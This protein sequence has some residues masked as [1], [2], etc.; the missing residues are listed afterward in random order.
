M[1]KKKK[2]AFNEE[3][4]KMNEVVKEQPVQIKRPD[5]AQPYPYLGSIPI[6]GFDIHRRK[7]R[8][9]LPVLVKSTTGDILGVVVIGHPGM[10]ELTAPAMLEK[11]GYKKPF[12][13]LYAD[14]LTAQEKSLMAL[15]L[16]SSKDKDLDVVSALAP[17]GRGSVGSI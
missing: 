7:Y 16:T 3:K 14:S 6:P 2:N 9:T 10:L 12:K 17:L 13:F 5:K 4:P 11:A 8:A 1:S 15:T